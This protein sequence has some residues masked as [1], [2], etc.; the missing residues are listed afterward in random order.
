MEAKE[1]RIGN[2]VNFEFHKDCG[3]VKGVEVF[4]SD[5]EII[6]HNSS[7][8]KYYTPIP[9]TE[10]WLLRFGF[11]KEIVFEAIRFNLFGKVIV[12]IHKLGTINFSL[13]NNSFSVKLKHVH[14]LQNL[15]FALTNEELKEV[16]QEINKL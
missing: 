7:K 3:G 14:Q 9:L 12:T 16:K 11:E 10:E 2:Y 1:L 6:L 4:I 8:S 5:L 15:Y 13:F